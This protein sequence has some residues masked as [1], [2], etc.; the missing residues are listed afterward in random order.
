MRKLIIILL[1]P[2]ILHL[3]SASYIAGDIYINEIGITRFDIDTDN[4]FDFDGLSYNNQIQTGRT[5]ILTSKSGAIWQFSLDLSDY[6]SII[7]DIHLPSPLITISEI[8]GPKNIIDFEKK[9]VSIIAT[10]TETLQISYQIKESKNLSWIGWLILILL[11]ITIFYI[12]TKI[13]KRKYRLDTLMPLIGNVEQKIIDQLM[14]GPIRQK[15]LRKKLDIP[16]ASY[17]RYLVNLEKKKLLIREGEGKNK[18]LRL[19]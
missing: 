19:K 8:S 2:L 14:K 18:I 16:K 5:E 17:S 9:T 13:K 6:D 3:V 1:F 4:P 12:T 7:L 11:L 15:E 10:S